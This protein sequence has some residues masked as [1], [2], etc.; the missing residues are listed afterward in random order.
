MRHVAARALATHGVRG[1]SSVELSRVWTGEAAGLAATELTLLSGR[2]RRVLPHLDAAGNALA[3]YADALEHTITRARALRARMAEAHTEH[4]RRV[5]MIRTSVADPVSCAAAVAAAD[6]R[7]A[8]EVATTRRHHG[9]LMSDFYAS[10][11]ACARALSAMSASTAP[12][13]STSDAITAEII[14]NLSLVR[15]QVAAASTPP[16]PPPAEEPEWWE[17]AL[18]TTGDAAV[19]AYNNAV[20]PAV[21]TAANLVEAMAEHP[22]DLIEMAMGAGMIFLG[23]GGEVGGFALDATGVGAVAGVPI[24]IA[25]AGLIA[26]GATA[27][28][29]GAGRLVE[30]AQ[31]KDHRW[32]HEVDG[33][34]TGRGKAGDP[35]P[36]SQRPSTAGS[37]WKGRVSDTR[38]G[39]VWQAPDKIGLGKGKPENADSV[40]IMDPKTDYPHGYVRFY[41]THGQPLDPHGKP[42]GDDVTHF[43]KRP[44]G[45]YDIPKGWNPS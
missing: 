43:P 45:S 6:R 12:A 39:E 38:K 4:T 2:S 28:G 20:V 10:G 17:T 35:L 9:A 27:V 15:Q 7:L 25:S 23:A 3:I 21:N 33:P 31:Q 24:N 16:P 14:G 34:S 41:N 13:G 37:N 29:Q 19:W 36:D 22:E 42:M 5:T 40:R 18:E 1:D 32:L 44:D 30:H 8:D 11:S 26:G